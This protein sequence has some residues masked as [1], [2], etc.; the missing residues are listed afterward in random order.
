[1]NPD[2]IMEFAEENCLVTV[3]FRRPS[4]EV[5]QARGFDFAKVR[6]SPRGGVISCEWIA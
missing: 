6:H 1:M 5:I 2:K 3:S 4:G